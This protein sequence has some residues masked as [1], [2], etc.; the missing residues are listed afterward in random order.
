MAIGTFLEGAE[1]SFEGFLSRDSKESLNRLFLWGRFV[2]SHWWSSAWSLLP[3]F[4]EEVLQLLVGASPCVTS[5]KGSLK[6][7]VTTGLHEKLALCAVE[8]EPNSS[9]IQARGNP[10]E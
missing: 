10:F 2:I 1:L 8:N 6:S 4:L 9:L 7:D 3:N 5:A